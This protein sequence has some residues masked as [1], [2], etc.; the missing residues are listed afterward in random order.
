MSVIRASVYR[1][2]RA[3]DRELRPPARAYRHRLAVDR[4]PENGQTVDL[5]MP[6][7]PMFLRGAGSSVE[8]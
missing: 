4:L 3:R 8:A 7:R 6:D 1:L 5:K 2:H